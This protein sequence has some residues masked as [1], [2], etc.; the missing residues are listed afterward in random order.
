MIPGAKQQDQDDIAQPAE[1]N[2][3]LNQGAPQFYNYYNQKVP[4]DSPLPCALPKEATDLMQKYRKKDGPANTAPFP[5]C[6]QSSQ[7]SDDVI[8]G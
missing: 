1:S 2:Q 3:R 6:R 4:A 7:R 5:R 8:E